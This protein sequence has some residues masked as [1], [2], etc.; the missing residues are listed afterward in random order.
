MLHKL[1]FLKNKIFIS[2]IIV[3]TIILSYYVGGVIGFSEG[4]NAGMYMEGTGAYTTVLTL[5][6]VRNDNKENAILLLE[7][8]LYSQLFKL[9]YFADS[10]DSVYNLDRFTTVRKEYNEHKEALRSLMIPVVDYLKAHPP[11][12]EENEEYPRDIYESTIN[13]YGR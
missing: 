9:E 6:N 2:T 11:D 1:G 7:S 13:K 4:F 8:S 5:N 12:S 3:L 10:N